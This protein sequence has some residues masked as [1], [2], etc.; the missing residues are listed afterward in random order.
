MVGCIVVNADG[1]V[2]GVST[3][4]VFGIGV[5]V[6][7]CACLEICAVVPCEVIA[8]I[9]VVCIVCAV[10]DCEVEGVDVG[11][12]RSWLRVVI[13]VGSACRV[14]L[15]IPVVVVASGYVVRCVIVVCYCEM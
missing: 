1:Q 10:V 13:G 8:C 5:V 11:A 6:N 9:L 2:Q 15:S 12:G 3:G 14:V 7:V 4:T